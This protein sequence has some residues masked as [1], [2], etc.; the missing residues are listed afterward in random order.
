M[1]WHFLKRVI[2]EESGN[3]RTPPGISAATV[4]PTVFSSIASIASAL[5]PAPKPPKINIPAPPP[6]PEPPFTP[7]SPSSSKQ[8]EGVSEE[9]KRRLRRRR[10]LRANILTGSILEEPPSTR[11]VLSGS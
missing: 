11:A 10:G 9:E 8:V 1:F 3:F 4:F 6:I 5:R 7:T 2:S